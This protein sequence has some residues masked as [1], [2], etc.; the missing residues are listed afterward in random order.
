MA[1]FFIEIGCEEIPAKMIPGSLE[2]GRKLLKKLLSN[3]SIHLGEIA[4]YAS[5]TRLI[6]HIPEIDLK[7]ADRTVTVQGPPRRICLNEDGTPS[8]ALQGFMKKN[9]ISEKDIRYIQ[10]KTGEIAAADVFIAGKSTD[11]ILK[12]IL[13]AWLKKIPFRKN[14]KWGNLDVRF[15][16]P[17]RWICAILDGAPLVFEY[18]GVTAGNETRGHRILGQRNIPVKTFGSYR[19]KLLQNHVNIDPKSRK[20][21]I[22]KAIEHFESRNN[23]TVIRDEGLLNEVSYLVEIPFVVEGTFE[24][25]FLEIPE[26]VL[27][28][29]MKE[30]QKYFA[31]RESDGKLLPRFLAVASTADDP[32][33]YIKLGS[34]RVLAARL[35]D[36]KFFW[37]EDRKKS[38]ESRTEKLNRQVFQTDLGTYGDKIRRMQKIAETMNRFLSCDAASLDKTIRLCKCDLASD[39]VYEFPELQGIM[40]GLYAKEEGEPENVWQGIYDHYLPGSMEDSLPRTREGELTAISD[41][42]DTFLG[43]LAVGIVPTGSKDPFGL[44][45]AAQGIIRIVLEKELDFDL[46]RAIENCMP[47]FDSVLKTDRDKWAEQAFSILD[48]RLRFWL[49]TRGFAYDEIDAVLAIP[50]GNL[51]DTLNRITALRESRKDADF[52]RVAGSFKRIH[53]ILDAAEITGSAE[54]TPTLFGQAEETALFDAMTALRQDAVKFTE[55]KD[56]AA[57][58]ERVGEIADTVDRFFDEVLVM[59]KNSAVKQNRLALLTRLREVFLG[60]ADFS[61]LVISESES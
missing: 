31:A 60:I 38:L 36:A 55:K 61:K 44:R 3:Y 59:D 28:T 50:H 47:V 49:N 16:R 42:L 52:L 48:A 43:C 51:L 56:Y 11:G 14:M 25:K 41:R 6:Y 26:E 53:N 22:Q 7:E 58:L 45:R 30:H 57:A 54:V 18:A 35:Y 15:V 19:E 1:E 2:E 5:P 33:G 39:M 12:E 10:G 32:K 13:P 20:T 23:A 29:S 9:G 46:Y 40:G 8:R 34:E 4:A 24:E 27:I 21:I 17:I 37:D